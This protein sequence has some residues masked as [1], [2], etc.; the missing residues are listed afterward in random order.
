MTTRTDKQDPLFDLLGILLKRKLS[1]I[2][3]FLSVFVVTIFG[4]LSLPPTYEANTSLYIETPAI[5]RVDLPY[6]QEIS[7][8]DF[9]NNQIQLLTSRMM[10]EKVVRKLDLHRAA[11]PPSRLRDLKNWAKNL[12][13]GD[14]PLPDPVGDAIQSLRDSI[15]IGMPRGTDICII[16]AQSRSPENAALF[17]NTLAEVYVQYANE[18]LYSR[19]RSAYEYLEEELREAQSKLTRSEDEL[20]RFRAQTMIFSAPDELSIVEQKLAQLTEQK[21]LILQKIET[22]RRAPGP[23]HPIEQ[24]PEK[25]QELNRQL[26]EAR[27]SLADALTYLKDQHPDV[28]MLQKTVVDLENR[29]SNELSLQDN[30]V[31]NGPASKPIRADNEEIRNQI[32]ALTA[33]NKHIS[34][35]IDKLSKRREELNRNQLALEKMARDVQRDHRRLTVLNAK[36]DESHLLRTDKTTGETIRIID[37]A[38]RPT[39]DSKKKMIIFFAVGTMVAVFFGI[40]MAFLSEYLDDSLSTPQEVTT[41][42]DL[43]ILGVVPKITRKLR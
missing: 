22:L 13:R 32:A 10:L 21:G 9:K 28:K 31:S 4:V 6:V 36:L 11:P 5:P 25:L 29:I 23:L 8:R 7:G 35:E 37:K 1:A 41:Y 15:S 42:L 18:L 30:T 27:A 2:I 26:E 43:P 12:L 16:T 20:D 19:K 38:F 24:Q 17:A 14:A 3:A 39:S 40:G 33:Q 34:D